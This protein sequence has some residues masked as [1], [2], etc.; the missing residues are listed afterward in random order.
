RASCWKYQFLNTSFQRNLSKAIVRY[1]NTSLIVTELQGKARQIY[2]FAQLLN[3]PKIF[4]Q[5]FM[6]FDF[7][8]FNPSLI[9]YKDGKD[10]TVYPVDALLCDFLSYIGYDIIIFSPSGSSDLENYLI[11]DE[12]DVHWLAE[13][14]VE[15]P[16]QEYARKDFSI[17]NIFK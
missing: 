4:L 5:Q 12:L 6:Q 17:K 2:I 3:I 8:S 10:H 14:K 16:Y 15:L 7:P 9:L 1:L 13:I 11:N